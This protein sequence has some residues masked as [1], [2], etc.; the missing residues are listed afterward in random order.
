M[1]DKQIDEEIEVYEKHTDTVSYKCSIN[2]CMV[3]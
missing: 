3:G 1:I 2:E